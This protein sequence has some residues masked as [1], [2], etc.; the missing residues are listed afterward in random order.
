MYLQNVFG[1]I[2]NTVVP[3]SH[4]LFPTCLV[5]YF[6]FLRKKKPQNDIFLFVW[7]NNTINLNVSRPP[8][9]FLMLFLISLLWARHIKR[10]FKCEIAYITRKGYATSQFI[11]CHDGRLILELK[12]NCPNSMV[13]FDYFFPFD[14]KTNPFSNCFTTVERW[15]RPKHE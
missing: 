9:S 15:L 4:H 8:S 1:R 13:W 7:Q 3:F 14:N 12:I 2:Y 10:K 5:F 11:N 6:L